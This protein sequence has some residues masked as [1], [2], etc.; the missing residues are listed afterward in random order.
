MACFFGHK[1]NGCT[2]SKCGKTRDEGHQW[3][4]VP[5]RCIEKCA[6]CGTEKPVA[7][8]FEPVEGKCLEKCS[9]CGEERP[10][11]HRFVNGICERCGTLRSSLGSAEFV[12]A[13]DLYPRAGDAAE[14]AKWLDSVIAGYRGCGSWELLEPA[15]RAYSDLFVPLVK[16]LKDGEF[17][18]SKYT[19]D[20][21][22]EIWG[23]RI[24]D[25]S[26]R[27]YLAERIENGEWNVPESERRF[28]SIQ[29]NPGT[30]NPGVMLH[31]LD[32]KLQPL[33]GPASAA[34]P[35]RLPEL[36]ADKENCDILVTQI[37]KLRCCD[38]EKQIPETVCLLL[39]EALKSS[40]S[41]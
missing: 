27:K 30:L 8:R 14:L 20:T 24:S 13:S 1:W 9:V 22:E 31:Y 2:C 39:T 40:F 32:S 3:Q 15:C 12:A 4:P 11:L 26:L 36:I 41:S 5:G 21:A 7:H 10:L 17:Y 18:G 37:Y 16:E 25:L 33:A 23:T 19:A 29:T 28:H 38:F 6:I 35:I 34:N